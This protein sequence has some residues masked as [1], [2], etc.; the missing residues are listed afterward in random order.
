VQDASVALIDQG[1]QQAD[2]ELLQNYY[3]VAMLVDTNPPPQAAS[4]G[5]INQARLLRNLARSHHASIKL[6]ESKPTKPCVVLYTSSISS[7]RLLEF[8]G[9]APQGNCYGCCGW[10]CHC[11]TDRGGVAIYH[12]Y[13]TQHD[14]CS[15]QY[16]RLGRPCLYSL[17]GSIVVVW[18][19]TR[20][21]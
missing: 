19:R 20:P 5:S 11:I 8:V 16:G 1:Y 18:W 10:G 7:N 17:I 3:A 21:A 14:T 9:A 15:G 6:T 4:R 12:T 13:C 2:P